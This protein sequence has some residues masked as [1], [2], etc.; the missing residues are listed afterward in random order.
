MK[1]Y[2]GNLPFSFSDKELS[3]LFA[4][5]GELAEASIIKDKQTGR[6]KGFGFVTFANY[7]KL[8]LG[9][10]QGILLTVRLII[11]IDRNN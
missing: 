6:S 1:V 2:V 9:N 10:A 7:L 4:V 3:E 11:L 5:Y 8:S